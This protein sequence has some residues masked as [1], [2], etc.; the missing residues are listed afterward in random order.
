MAPHARVATR[1]AAADAYSYRRNPAV[2]A[3]P[4]DK[5]LIVYDGVCVLCSTAMRIIAQR[6]RHARFRY[7]SAQS[8]L[9]QALFRHYRFDPGSFETVLLLEDG[10]AYGKLD[11]ARRVAAEIGGIYQMFGL[12]AVLP[13]ALQDWCYD[14]IAKNRYRLFGRSDVCIL[15]DPS[16]RARVID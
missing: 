16:W 4:D 5:P 3:F 13:G 9:G 14:R 15:P 7:A 1:L 11:M 6:D 8:P 2:P 10:R 12:F